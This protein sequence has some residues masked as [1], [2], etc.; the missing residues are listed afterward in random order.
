[1][2]PASS[3]SCA[4]AER[5]PPARVRRINVERAGSIEYVTPGVVTANG[6]DY[7]PARRIALYW[8]PVLLRRLCTIPYEQPFAS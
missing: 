1:M 3:R 2:F 6:L 5:K 8:L 4:S 7:Q